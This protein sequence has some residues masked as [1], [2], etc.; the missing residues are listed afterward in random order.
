MAEDLVGVWSADH[1]YGPGAQSDEL[2]VFRE[3]GTGYWQYMSYGPSSGDLFHWKLLPGDIL[4]LTAYR[5][6]GPNA[7]CSAMEEHDESGEWESPI[8]IAHEPTK[9]GRW[10][11]V[12]RFRERPWKYAT[13]HYGFVSRSLG[14]FEKPDLSV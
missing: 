7:E 1:M 14:N 10:M 9:A 4:H 3:D 2:F 12:L 13:D 6:F 8:T 11:R 5:Q